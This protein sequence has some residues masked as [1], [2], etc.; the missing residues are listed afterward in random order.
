MFKGALDLKC[1]FIMLL[2]ILAFSYLSFSQN[3]CGSL[4]WWLDKVKEKIPVQSLFTVVAIITIWKLFSPWHEFWHYV[5]VTSEK[6][7]LLLYF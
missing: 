3:S 1:P 7:F 5:A 6:F 4:K 2:E